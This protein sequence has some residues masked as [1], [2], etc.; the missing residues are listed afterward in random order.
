MITRL[1]LRMIMIPVFCV[2][3]LASVFLK[4][5][6]KVSSWALVIFWFVMVIASVFIIMEKQYW[7]LAI[8][9]ISV[10]GSFA[11]MFAVMD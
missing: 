11:I 5:I 3:A 6:E 2:L 1:L 10:A 7:Q 4:A 9:G 8:V